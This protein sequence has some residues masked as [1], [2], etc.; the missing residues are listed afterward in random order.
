MGSGRKKK[1]RVKSYIDDLMKYVLIS[2][3]VSLFTVLFFM[4]TLGI[5][6]YPLVMLIYGIWLFISGGA[7]KFRPLIIGGIVNWLLGITAF[8]FAFEIQLLILAL[9][10]LLG[11]IIPGHLLKMK[12]EISKRIISH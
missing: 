11:Y 10:V 3:L 2:F 6:T 9:A 5:S 1:Q 4:N 8:F 7:L 12:F